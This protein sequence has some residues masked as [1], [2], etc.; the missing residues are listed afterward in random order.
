MSRRAKTLTPRRE[1]R[2]PKNYNLGTQYYK[3]VPVTLILYTEAHFAVLNAK[4]FMLGD[5]RYN[6]NVWIPNKYLEPDG[7]LKAGWNLDWLFQKAARQNKFRLA[8]VD[9]NPW[10]W[11]PHDWEV[12]T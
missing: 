9:V 5:P 2:K 4:R 1:V 12:A 11:Q 3:G 8:H 6:Q 7:T 10:T